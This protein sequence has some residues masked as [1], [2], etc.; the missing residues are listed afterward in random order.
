[1][2]EE[3]SS[4]KNYKEY[5]SKKA[6]LKNGVLQHPEE[7]KGGKSIYDFMQNEVRHDMWAVSYNEFH[8]RINKKK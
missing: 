8:K 4:W 1:M 2:S 6:K 5:N 3:H 7:G